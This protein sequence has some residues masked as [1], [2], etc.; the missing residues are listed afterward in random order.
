MSVLG[1]VY[2]FNF[3][4]IVLLLHSPEYTSPASMLGY[5]CLLVTLVDAL[6]HHIN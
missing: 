4:Y 2:I 6:R 3:Q 5:S 1:F